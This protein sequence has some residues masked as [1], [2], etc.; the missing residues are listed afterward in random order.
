MNVQFPWS[1]QP[2]ISWLPII[3][4]GPVPRVGVSGAVLERGERIKGSS[5]S[6]D[7]DYA[8]N[9]VSL[10]AASVNSHRTIE[11]PSEDIKHAP[12]ATEQVIIEPEKQTF[13]ARDAELRTHVALKASADMVAGYLSS[14]GHFRKDYTWK[15]MV[16]IT[17]T[18]ADAFLNWIDEASQ[19]ESERHSQ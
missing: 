14:S 3:E 7:A 6:D 1:N 10:E 11:K 5:G 19:R 9:I 16:E 15:D 2:E 4:G 12:A 8:W 18:V 13:T 17:T